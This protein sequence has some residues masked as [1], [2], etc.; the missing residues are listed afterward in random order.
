MSAKHAVIV[1]AM[2]A[3]Q[4]YC[5]AVCVATARAATH[6]C[7][8]QP[9][10]PRAMPDSRHLVE[11]WQVL[12]SLALMARAAARKLMAAARFINA[13]WGYLAAA[14]IVS[15]LNPRAPTSPIM[16]PPISR[17]EVQR[18][19][20]ELLAKQRTCDH[21]L[22]GKSTIDGRG[23][24]KD[25]KMQT[26]R[27][28]LK[29]W[30]WDAAAK[31]WKEKQNPK[32]QTTLLDYVQVHGQSSSSSAAGARPKASPKS[33][34][35]RSRSSLPSAAAPIPVPMED[36]EVATEEEDLNSIVPTE[37]SDEDF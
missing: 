23:S 33:S 5:R 8:A 21:T 15:R 13:P 34:S 30:Y 2:S 28:C 20:S 17:E 4:C 11:R 36:W 16:P 37:P 3:Q 9:R 19:Q 22:L 26:C 29:R 35:G 31:V 10:S 14:G 1:V 6:S 24:G 25:V 12:M 27:Q 32:L 7:T 18:Q